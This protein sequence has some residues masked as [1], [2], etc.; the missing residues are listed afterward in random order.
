MVRTATVAD[1]QRP[2]G[3]SVQWRGAPAQV[4][5][6]EVGKANQGIVPEPHSI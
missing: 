5:A 4:A 3:V 1:R 6:D 2:N